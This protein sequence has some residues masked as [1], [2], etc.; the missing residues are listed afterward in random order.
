[1]P[2]EWD[3]LGFF[4]VAEPIGG[5]WNEHAYVFWHSPL[6]SMRPGGVG[7]RVSLAIDPPA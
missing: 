5:F 1:M 3:G 4:L 6:W 2:N 7:V